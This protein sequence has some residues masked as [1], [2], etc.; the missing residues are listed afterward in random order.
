MIGLASG[1]ALHI[2]GDTAIARIVCKVKD[3]DEVLEYSSAFIQLYR[4]EAFFLEPAGRFLD[5]VGLD[6]VRRQVLDDANLRRELHGRL[7]FARQ[8][9]KDPWPA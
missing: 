9:Y 1:Y 4:E 6:H 5:R 3:D 7:L 8:R 2:G